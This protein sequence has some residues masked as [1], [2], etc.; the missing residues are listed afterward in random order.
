MT[1]KKVFNLIDGTFT[2]EEAKAL[3]MALYGSKIKYHSIG[4]IKHQEFNGSKSQFHENR[5]NELRLERDQMLEFLAEKKEP[6][7][8]TS[9]F[10][11]N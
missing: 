11:I 2:K 1:T 8:I 6:I 10:N 9:F 3:P 5:I 7:C 4:A